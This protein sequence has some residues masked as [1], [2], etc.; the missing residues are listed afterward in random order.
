MQ[1]LMGLLMFGTM[2]LLPF[3]VQAEDHDRDHDRDDRNPR[4]QR[5]YDSNRRD[6]HEW[7]EDEQRAYR[8]YQKEHHR[9]DDDFRKASKRHQRD[10]W[11]WR[12]EHQDRY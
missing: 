12:H 11:K 5:Y 4:V 3:K 7:N 10:Y 1:K 2:L 8:H 9:D 6:Y